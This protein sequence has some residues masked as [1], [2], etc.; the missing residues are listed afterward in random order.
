MRNLRTAFDT[1]DVDGSNKIDFEE[2]EAVILALHH[3]GNGGST[4]DAQ[5]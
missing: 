5:L 1:A 4:I 3:T 2:F